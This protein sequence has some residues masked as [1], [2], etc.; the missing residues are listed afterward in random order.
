MQT[1]LPETG[2]IYLVTNIVRECHDGREKFLQ[3]L[4][5]T[6]VPANAMFWT[7]G[8]NDWAEVRTLGGDILFDAPENELPI[9]EDLAQVQWGFRFF[10]ISLVA[11]LISLGLGIGSS[12]TLLPTTMA[13]LSY[14][15]SIIGLLKTARGLDWGVLPT[16][17]IGILLSIPFL[18]WVT[19]IFL[20]FNALKLVRSYGKIS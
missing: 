14:A 2:K 19:L 3:R 18:N 5:A 15:A 17:G 7:E 10:T 12:S 13:V 4:G 8:M 6:R 20:A 1:K 11:A 16:L 9:P